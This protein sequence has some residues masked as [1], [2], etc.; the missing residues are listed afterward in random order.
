MHGVCVT[1]SLGH[2]L[3]R[4]DVAMT[5][6]DGRQVVVGMVW[7]HKEEGEN[8]LGMNWDGIG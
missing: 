6:F 1:P 7:W 2:C 5:W 8:G 4:G 3:R